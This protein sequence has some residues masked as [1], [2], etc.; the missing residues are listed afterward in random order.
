MLRHTA[1]LGVVIP[2]FNS[3]DLWQKKINVDKWK[4]NYLACMANPCYKHWDTEPVLLSQCCRYQGYHLCVY[5]IV[6]GLQK[7]TFW[8]CKRLTKTRTRCSSICN[9]IKF[10]GYNHNCRFALFYHHYF[11]S[12]LMKFSWLLSRW[13]L[14]YFEQPAYE[15]C[16]YR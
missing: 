16:T 3:N 2:W 12:S 13:W 10:I 14:S 11:C 6:Q 5:I 1:C 9:N 7:T 8:V 15:Y 4:S